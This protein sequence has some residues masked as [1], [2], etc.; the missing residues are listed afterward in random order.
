MA[1]VVAGLRWLMLSTSGT[2]LARHEL[3]MIPVCLSEISYARFKADKTGTLKEGKRE[4]E[5][6]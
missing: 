3:Q 1:V 5:N 4:R 2:A 6:N